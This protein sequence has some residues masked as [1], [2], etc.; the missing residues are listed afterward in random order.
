MTKD[1][2]IKWLDKA[3]KYLGPDSYLGGTFIDQREGIVADIRNDIL[4]LQLNYLRKLEVQAFISASD[5]Q[6]TCYQLQEQLRALQQEI[7]QAE[8][9]RDA[10]KS[11]IESL[12]SNAS[13][14]ISMLK[15]MAA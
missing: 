7:K 4:P 2:E 12:R 13:E 6:K 11:E 1:E 15:R 10:T 3:I 14:A 9:K 5:T 8:W